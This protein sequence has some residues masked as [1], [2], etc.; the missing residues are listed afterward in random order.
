LTP[1]VRRSQYRESSTPAEARTSPTSRWATEAGLTE[2]GLMYHF[3][4]KDAMMVA[5]IEHVIELGS[6][7]H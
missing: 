2:A 1:S 7:A 6:Q 4:S 5:V 3:P